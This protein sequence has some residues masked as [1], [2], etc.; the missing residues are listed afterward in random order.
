[1][2]FH[3]IEY[4][5]LLS[6]VWVIAWWVVRWSLPLRNLILLVASY[7]FYCSWDWRFAGLLVFSTLLD[8]AVGW[9]LYR[10]ERISRKRLLLC[11][12]LVGNLGVLCLFKYYNFFIDNLNNLL[13]SVE[14][15]P[16][17][18]HL[19]LV[20]PLGISFYT[21]QTLSYTLDIYRGRLKPTTNLFDFA[22]FVVFFPQ[23]IAGPIVRARQ[24]LP[25]LAKVVGFDEERMISGI[26]RIIKGLIKK[27]V[28]ADMIGR[29]LVDPVF[30]DPGG[31]TGLEASLA[32]LGFHM[33]IGFDFGAYADIAIGSARL[34]GFEIPE[35]FRAQTRATDLEDFWRR[36][37]ITLTTWIRDYLYIPLAMRKRDG[38]PGWPYFAIIFTMVLV[39]LWHGASWTFILFGLYHGIGLAITRLLRRRF[40]KNT[41]EEPTGF[42]F[43]L[44]IALKR[45]LTIM[46][47]AVSIVLFR[48]ANLEDAGTMY[49]AMID[50]SNWTTH[51]NASGVGSLFLRL[52]FVLHLTSEPF[53][54][55]VEDRFLKLP[56]IL[57]AAVV[58]FSL[59]MVAM[60][61]DIGRP[62]VYFQF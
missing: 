2:L 47:V 52:A 7:V 43:H 62:F 6:A 55:S 42:K 36:W 60:Y 35:N 17:N 53:R 19:E 58:V 57:Q 31:A 30:A 16:L 61:L 28:I 51:N 37:H 14:M 56:V 40:G 38:H 44:R 11:L 41:V 46:L 33:Q 32:M 22:L 18:A 59:A 20:L 54:Q 29:L 34:L 13:T 48:A 23:L 4:A 15:P 27:V 3:T 1:M 45:A 12:S 49:F 5:L 26:Y 10:C 39:G 50:P 25:Q 9:Y 24:F 21:F 8:Y